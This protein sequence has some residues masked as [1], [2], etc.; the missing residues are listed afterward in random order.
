LD[1]NARRTSLSEFNEPVAGWPSSPQHD[2]ALFTGKPHGGGLS[3][4]QARLLLSFIDENHSTR[5]CTADLAARIS[6]SESHLFRVFRNTFGESPMRFV[7]RR[8]M[9]HAEA[10]LCVPSQ[11]LSDIAI[12][13]GFCDQAHFTRTCRRLLGVSPAQWRC[14]RRNLPFPKS[15][16]PI[17]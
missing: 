14:N 15:A 17:A 7:T 12:L 4:W 3:Q 1:N 2:L 13:C 16:E 8:R 10:L 5:I 6:V 11:S 9:R